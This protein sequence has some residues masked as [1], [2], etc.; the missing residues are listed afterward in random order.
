MSGRR[1]YLRSGET[2]SQAL[3]RFGSGLRRG[4]PFRPLLCEYVNGAR[5]AG[6]VALP[7]TNAVILTRKRLLLE[8]PF[9][10]RYARGNGYREES[11][12]QMNL[13]VNGF[14]I[15][16]TNECHSFHLPLSQV[17]TG[18]QRT[19]PLFRLYWSIYYTSYFFAKYY[20]RYAARLGL[21]SPRWL[22][23]AAFAAFAAYRETLRPALHGVAMWALA[24]RVPAMRLPAA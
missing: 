12:F 2:R 7:I 1:I 11:D 24:R 14:D 10:G 20:A 5:F 6:D 15:Y 19:R 8:F 22:A 21:K 3:A 16:A 18:G 17:R 4:K 13:F 23:L 9:D